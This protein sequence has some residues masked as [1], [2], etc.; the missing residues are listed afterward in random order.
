MVVT[1]FAL[2]GD[3]TRTVHWPVI[4]STVPRAVARMPETMEG[5]VTAPVVLQS[6][7]AVRSISQG[8]SGTLPG[9]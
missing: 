2:A 5:S 8:P 4:G 9:P 1:A 3:P 6:W 7:N